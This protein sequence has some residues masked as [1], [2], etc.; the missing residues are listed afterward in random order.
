MGERRK[1]ERQIYYM[2]IEAK[3][4]MI[5]SQQAGDLGKLMV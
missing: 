3:K 2:I 5:Y 1:R 4:S